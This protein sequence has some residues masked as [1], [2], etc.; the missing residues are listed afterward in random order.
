MYKCI[1][2]HVIKGQGNVLKQLTCRL[3][4]SLSSVAGRVRA[5]YVEDGAEGAARDIATTAAKTAAAF[6]VASAQLGTPHKH[7]SLC[8][9]VFYV[10]AVRWSLC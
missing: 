3:R 2:R 10:C 5:L 9:C 8:V 6:Q 1:Y 4:L 7:L